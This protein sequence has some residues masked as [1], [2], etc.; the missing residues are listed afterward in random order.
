MSQAKR[1]RYPSGRQEQYIVRLPDGMRDR[2]KR[3]AA[4]HCRSMNAE[5]V[6]QLNRAYGV[7][8]TKKA[9]ARA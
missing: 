9:D 4:H 6:F 7:D 1:E 3:E 5:I 2:I 8:E